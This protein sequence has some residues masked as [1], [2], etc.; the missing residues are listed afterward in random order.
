MKAQETAVVL[1]EFQNEFCKD[2]GKLNP[3]VNSEISRQS[4]IENA[5]KLSQGARE[6]GAMVIHA[7]FI[8]NPDYY[9]EHH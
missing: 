4:T 3:G 9:E 2:G 5:V 1:I 7:P 8:F 6:K